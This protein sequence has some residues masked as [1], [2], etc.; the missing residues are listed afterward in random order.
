MTDLPARL[1]PIPFADLPRWAEDRHGEAM[2]AFL[3]SCRRM[4]EAPPKTRAL[5]IDGPSLARIGAAALDAFAAGPPDD[6]AARAFFEAH[7]RPHRVVPAE[8]TPFLTGYYEPEVDGSRVRTERFGVPLLARPHDL[9]ELDDANR[10]AGLDPTLAFAR[11]L[12]DGG[13]VPYFDRGEIEDG[14]IGDRG[15][16]IVWLESA[17]EAFFVHVQGSARVRLADGSGTVRVTYDGKAG[18]P[19]TSI[20]RRLVER[21]G[22]APET[23]TADVLRAWLEANGQAGRALMRENRSYVFFEVVDGLD[24][25]LGAIAAAKVQIT[26]GRSLAVDRTLHTFGT[27]IFLDADLPAP[28]DGALRP[29]RRLMVAQDTG[30]AIVG[31]ARG[32]V[33]FG[34]GPAAARI[35]GLIRHSPRAF[36]VLVP[37]A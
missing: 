37:E 5:G 34:S 35:A 26:P 16:E 1:E 8:G 10:P 32:D 21:L 17:V 27:P 12:P 4:A 6:R 7:F 2:A 20:G 22:V 25:D 30:S 29:F 24:P 14:A 15:L 11:R 19:Y 13:L 9:I 18:W 33:F 23:M 3:L 36:V 31:P 28:P